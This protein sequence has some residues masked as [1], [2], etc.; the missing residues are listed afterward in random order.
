M[1][2]RM[3]AC[4]A[5]CRCSG[6]ER[7]TGFPLQPGLAPAPP[8]A[9]LLAGTHNRPARPARDEDGALPEW[10][11]WQVAGTASAEAIGKRDVPETARFGARRIAKRP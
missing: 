6:R 4:A 8:A 7:R 5:R 3:M 11:R 1:P 10:E 2:R 9:P